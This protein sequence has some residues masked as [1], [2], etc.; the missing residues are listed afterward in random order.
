[1]LAL[2][3]PS[4]LVAQEPG[5]GTRRGPVAPVYAEDSAGPAPRRAWALGILGYG[6]GQWQPNGVEFALLWRA[7]NSTAVGPTIA[8]GTF[9]QSQAVLFGAS[10]GFFVGLGLTARQG[11]VTLLDAGTEQRPAV[12]KIELDADALL[13]ADLATP[14]PQGRWDLRLDLL[15]GLTYGAE[16]ST[17][18]SVGIYFGPSVFI[19]KVATTHTQLALR[20]RMPI[21]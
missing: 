15:P 13:A 2:F 20:F 5:G 18:Q 12:V 16:S 4:L 19:G 8:L 9:A 7:T 1:M 10:S 14:M 6:G 11:L 3:C 21:R 17:G